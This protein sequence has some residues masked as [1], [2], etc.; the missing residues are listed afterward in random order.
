[1][2]A[3]AF[4]L[5]A[6]ASLRPGAK[7]GQRAMTSDEVEKP[8]CELS[9]GLLR[10]LEKPVFERRSAD[11]RKPTTTRFIS[12]FFFSPRGHNHRVDQV[13]RHAF[14]AHETFLSP[15]RR[16]YR[17]RQLGQS[18]IGPGFRINGHLKPSRTAIRS[19]TPNCFAVNLQVDWAFQ[20]YISVFAR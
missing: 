11:S 10:W 8:D 18:C 15:S 9:R 5:S 6:V 19:R 16:P 13:G 17:D 3:C 14:K 2:S 20:I 7:T 12:F 4:C 1:L